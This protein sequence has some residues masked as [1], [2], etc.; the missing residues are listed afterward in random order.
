MTVRNYD[1]LDKYV[2]QQANYWKRQGLPAD[3][4]S[5][6]AEEI[7]VFGDDLLEA[8]AY[9]VLQVQWAQR[10]ETQRLEDS[11]GE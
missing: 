11:N 6:V 1:W 7:E 4:I 5:Q 3:I 2:A 9:D 8:A 10:P